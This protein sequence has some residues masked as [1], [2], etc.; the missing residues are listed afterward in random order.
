MNQPLQ[1]FSQAIKGKKA[2]VL[3]I[4]ISNTPL[5]EFLVRLGADVTAFDRADAE[6]LSGRLS[7]LKEL[8]VGC[9]LGPDY[10]SGLKGF[11]WVFKT[12][13][14]RPD[15]P[16]LAA[17]RARGAVVTSEMEVFFDLCP[18]TI[19][20]VTG[21]DGKTTTT[22][23][24]CEMLKAHGYVCH[25]GGNIGTPLLSKVGEIAPSDMTI[26]ELSSF[27][28][29]TMRKSPHV[30]VV[31]NLSPNHLD[32]HK[33][34]QEYAEAKKQIFL[35]QRED[36]LCVL[37]YD[38]EAARALCGEVPGRLGLFSLRG[39][40]PT[41]GARGD[42]AKIRPDV[43]AFVRDG[44]VWVSHAD[45]GTN[46]SAGVGTN[47]STS[48]GTA[49]GPYAARLLDVRDIRLLGAHNIEN[50]L[51][52]I[53][54]VERYVAPEHIRSTARGFGGVEHR[55]EFVRALRG[56]RYYND[57]IATSPTRTIACLA[58]FPEKIILIAGGKDKNLDFS[59]LAA[60]LA[61]SVKLLILC[62]QTSGKIRAAL[63]DGL[64]K[65]GEPK[66]AV[67]VIECDG[68]EDAVR[69][70]WQNAQA[71]DTVV[72][73]PASTSFDRFRNFE[74]RGRLFKDLVNALP[75]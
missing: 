9:R 1:A 27:Q 10:L 67:P 47:M 41:A 18:S 40:I 75:D 49:V 35:H 13:A 15:I 19:F 69:A 29:Q 39:G 56:V 16:E 32:V 3:G 44:A 61:A 55:L 58:A 68:Y 43:S 50:Y 11:D 63:L 7:R 38:N 59:P 73:S 23:L 48:A 36:G 8:D 70:A 5:I 24:I 28:L 45:A 17:E 31:T 62:G 52:A 46:M 25:L 57:S 51:A 12:P 37:N 26:V 74:E 4:G 22:T 54:A 64:Q 65:R 14:I 66:N 33:S 20:G 2:A 21:S 42:G 6:Q 53:C 60:P 30:A 72:L 71:N 34:Y